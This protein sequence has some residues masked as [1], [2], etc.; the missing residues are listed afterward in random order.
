MS[1]SPWTIN[2]LATEFAIDRRTVA[3]RL[4]RLQPVGTTPQGTPAY[5]LQDA[6]PLLTQ[7]AVAGG[8]LDLEEAR[9]RKLIAEAR[10]AELEL[11][12]Q[13]REVVDVAT[14]EALVEEHYATVRQR[15]RAIPARLAGQLAVPEPAAARHVLQQA[16]E[17][18]LAELEAAP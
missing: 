1:A 10:L 16:I 12:R 7:D 18:A 11:A 2:R 6:A 14:V 4:A 8:R 13:S 15:L 17:E 5:V 3:R 9:R